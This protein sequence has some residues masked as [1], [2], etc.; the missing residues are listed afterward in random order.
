M[1]TRDTTRIFGAGMLFKLGRGNAPTASKPCEGPVRFA[2]GSSV[3]DG[4][5]LL[6]TS[7]STLVACQVV[8]ALLA[9]LS[10]VAIPRAH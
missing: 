7:T 3:Q 6:A 2:R 5:S 10:A 4:S 8:L 1:A 9:V